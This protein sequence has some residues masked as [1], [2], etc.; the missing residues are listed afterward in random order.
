M[1]RR[2]GNPRVPSPPGRGLIKESG[3]SSAGTYGS[4]GAW[5]EIEADAKCPFGAASGRVERPRINERRSHRHIA[6]VALCA[7]MV[8]IGATVSH[9]SLGETYRGRDLLDNRHVRQREQWCI[10]F[11]TR[12]ALTDR[13]QRC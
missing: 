5:R 9:Q 13:K 7:R 8:D 4:S 12:L 10:A 6:V 1:M 11:H 3:L 2:P